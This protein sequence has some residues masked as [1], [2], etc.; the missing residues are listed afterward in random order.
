MYKVVSRGIGWN[1]WNSSSCNQLLFQLAKISFDHKVDLLLGSILVKNI[2]Q[3]GYVETSQI[4]VQK[5]MDNMVSRKF[6]YT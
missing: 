6:Y 2:I 4:G 1:K 5:I 3:I